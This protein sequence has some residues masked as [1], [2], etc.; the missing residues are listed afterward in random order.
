M[1]ALPTF[2]LRFTRKISPGVALKPMSGI[3]IMPIIGKLCVIEAD[4][5]DPMAVADLFDTMPE[6]R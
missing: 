2:F 6:F 3:G 5:T 4:S 1:P